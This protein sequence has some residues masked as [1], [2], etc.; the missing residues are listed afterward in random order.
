MPRNVSADTP[1]TPRKRPVQARSRQ[2]VEAILEAAAQ[3]LEVRGYAAATTDRIAERAGVS[4]GTLYQYFPNKD[5]I[6]LALAFCHAAEGAR[7]LLPLARELHEA[8]PPIEDGLRRLVRIGVASHRRAHLHRVLFA[9]APFPPAVRQ[10]MEQADAL[11]ARGLARYL[12]RAPGARAP[13][14]LL[15]A[16]LVIDAL[17]GLLHG[18]VL[19]PPEGYDEAACEAEVVRMLAA[20]LQG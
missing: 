5:A 10:G 11:L 2:T 17:A 19:D 6:L 12:E 1:V 4:V 15:A 16:H 13:D 20:Y 7:E 8:P 9:E 14:P 3:V 18:F